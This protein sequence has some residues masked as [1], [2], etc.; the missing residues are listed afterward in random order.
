MNIEISKDF[1]LDANITH[2]AFKL[3][4]LLTYFL[5]T[6]KKFT[7]KKLA[8]KLNITQRTL[9]RAINNLKENNYLKIERINHTKYKYILLKN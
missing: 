2:T 6:N 4:C 8:K 1:L 3:L 7:Q 5:N 9:A